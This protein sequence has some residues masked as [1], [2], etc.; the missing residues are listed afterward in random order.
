MRIMV[1]GKS[2][3]GKS[4]FST[5]LGQHLGLPVV[6]LDKL[7]FNADWSLAQSKEA[8]DALVTQ[9]I[10]EDAWIIDGNYSKTIDLRVSRSEVIVFFDTSFIR[11]LYFV[12]KRMLSQGGDASDKHTGM[13]QRVT[14]KLI[15]M[16]YMYPTD[17]VME[18]LRANKN[19]DLH[20][21]KN[22][23]QAQKLLKALTQ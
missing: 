9:K 22:H 14:W 12:C 3:A 19:A 8:F 15:R 17:M 4:V 23:T 21:V 6:H 2:G 10:M 11:S 1:V 18:K 13:K 7:Y 16:M 20:I 5:K